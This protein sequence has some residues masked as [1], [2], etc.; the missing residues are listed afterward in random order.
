MIFDCRSNVL[1]SVPILSQVTD[2]YYYVNEVVTTT[3]CLHV[4]PQ[5]SCR[6]NVQVLTM[7]SYNAHNYV[8]RNSAHHLSGVGSSVIH[9]R[10]V[11][12]TKH[13]VDINIDT[14]NPKAKKTL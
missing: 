2:Y 13:V 14:R 6:W 1:Y 3:F 12:V 4:F 11:K 5:N 10:P 8:K 9:R 7:I